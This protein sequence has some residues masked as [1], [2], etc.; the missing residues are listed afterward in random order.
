MLKKTGSKKKWLIVALPIVLAL[1]IIA[2][3]LTYSFLYVTS[4]TVVGEVNG[5]EIYAGEIKLKMNSAKADAIA[6]FE[7]KYNITAGAD[8]WETEF[9]GETPEHYLRENALAEIASYK[10]QLQLGQKYGLIDDAS[11]EALVEEITSKNLDNSK[12]IAEGEPVYGQ[13]TYS[14]STY[15]EYKLSNLKLSLQK[16]MFEEGEPLYAQDSVLLDY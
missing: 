8:F 4:K 16:K 14:L 7:D 12:K 9:D 10:L 2:V 3:T 11:Y 6:Y 5:M 15:Y 1:I 13:K